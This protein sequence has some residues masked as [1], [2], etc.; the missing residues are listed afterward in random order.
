MGSKKGCAVNFVLLYLLKTMVHSIAKKT[1]N[2]KFL[3]PV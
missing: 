2:C 1:G 3:P